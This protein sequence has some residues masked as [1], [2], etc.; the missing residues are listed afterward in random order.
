MVLT[1]SKAQV[2][3]GV[4]LIALAKHSVAQSYSFLDLAPSQG[5]T[6]SHAKGIN[7]LRQVVGWSTLDSGLSTNAT[8]WTNAAAVSLDSL[9][10]AQSLAWSINDSGSIVGYSNGMDFPEH[11][12]RWDGSNL[13][14]LNPTTDRSSRATAI[15]NA[16]QIFGWGQ[17]TDS[18]I[19][20]ITWDGLLATN[21]GTTG[22]M[23]NCDLA[24]SICRQNDKGQAV[25]SYTPTGSSLSH[26]IIWNGV[27]SYDDNYT[28]LNTLIDPSVAAS[29]WVLVSATGINNN[30]DIVGD[31]V[32]TITGVTHAYILTSQVP[33]QSTATMFLFGLAL[34]AYSV[35]VARVK[36]LCAAA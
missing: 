36:P 1:G 7:N 32:N 9:G 13:I 8:L 34:L 35:R 29:G 6:E 19:H 23:A 20:G 28:D 21:T 12:V 15:N 18:N 10:G 14:D 11:A 3:I 5:Q 33:E 17:S 25:D 24:P 4:F 30:G 26:A 16:G 27:R 22:L 2:V 31:A